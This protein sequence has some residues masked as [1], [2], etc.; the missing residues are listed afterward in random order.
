[1]NF[2]RKTPEPPKSAARTEL[3][4]AV[5]S[6]KAAQTTVSRTE[7]AIS[8][9]T[10]EIY[11]MQ[12][13]IV[14]MD[15]KLEELKRQRVIEISNAALNGEFSSRDQSGIGAVLAERA[16]LEAEIT[17][18]RQAI[19]GMKEMRDRA[20]KSLPSKGMLTENAAKAVMKIE[21]FDSYLSLQIFPPGGKC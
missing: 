3:E 4:T 17:V 9:T 12:D 18:R 15:A 6:L 11:T 5:A 16:N 20:E 1:M 2:L 21:I 10:Q 8:R 13:E 7:E 19:E 14:A